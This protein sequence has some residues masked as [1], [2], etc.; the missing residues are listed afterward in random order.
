MDKIDVQIDLT[1][2]VET[3]MNSMLAVEVEHGFTAGSDGKL[4]GLVT[5]KALRDAHGSGIT[6]IDGLIDENSPRVLENTV[7]EDLVSTAA[8]YDFPI[9]V[10]D[11]QGNIK[12]E[13]RRTAVLTS[14]APNV[15]PNADVN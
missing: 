3:A 15:A 8:N 11:D 5:L 14:L 9:A 1:Q 7:V 10:V 13:V 12:G 4:I 6:S 2:T